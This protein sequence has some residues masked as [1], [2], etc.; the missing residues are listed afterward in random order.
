MH[1]TIGILTAMSVEYNQVAAM[2]H[3]TETVENGPQAFL[4]G[5]IGENKVVLLQCGIGKTN[6]AMGLTNLLMPFRPDYGGKN[7]PTRPTEPV[8]VNPVET[9][10]EDVVTIME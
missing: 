7:V 8:S 10:G 3:D 1:K 5:T 2:M 4:V 9:D 6:A